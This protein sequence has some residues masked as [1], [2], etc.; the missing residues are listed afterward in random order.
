MFLTMKSII[1][2]GT[3]IKHGVIEM[4]VDDTLYIM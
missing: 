3:F 2:N 4:V 1:Y